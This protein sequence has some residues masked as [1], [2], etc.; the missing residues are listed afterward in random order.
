MSNGVF[1]VYLF[2]PVDLAW[3]GFLI[4]VCCVLKYT[5]DLVSALRAKRKVHTFKTSDGSWQVLVE[6]ATHN[7][8]EAAMVRQEL[9]EHL[10]EQLKDKEVEQND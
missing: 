10:R 5:V 8:V 2:Q 4:L 6:N 3:L 9:R 1:E 7:D